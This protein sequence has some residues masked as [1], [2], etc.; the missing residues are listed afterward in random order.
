MSGEGQYLQLPPAHPRGA[1]RAA[2]QGVGTHNMGPGTAQQPAAHQSSQPQAPSSSSAATLRAGADGAPPAGPGAASRHAHSGSAFEAAE[3]AAAPSEV[4]SEIVS[5]ARNTVDD[6]IDADIF[7]DVD[8]ADVGVVPAN[9]GVPGWQASGVG[10]EVAGET[11]DEGAAGESDSER[12]TTVQSEASTAGGKKTKRRTRRKGK[13]TIRINLEECK[14]EVMR[15][16]RKQVGWREASGDQWWDVR[17][18]DTSVGLERIMRLRRLQKINHFHGMLEICRKNRMARN[19]RRMQRVLPDDFA[20]VPKTYILP[21]DSNELA[22]AIRSRRKRTFIVKPDAGCQ[23]KG[24]RLVQTQEQLARVLAELEMLGQANVVAQRYLSKPLLINGYKFD[25]RIYVL[26]AAVDPLRVFMYEDGLV[27]FA[28]SPYEAP[29]GG[30]LDTA[31]MHLTNYSLNKRTEGFQAASTLDG[32]DG[33]KWSLSAL[34]AWMSG[35]GHDYDKLMDEIGAIAVKTVMSIQ[36]LL[37][38]YYWSAVPAQNDGFSCFEVLGLDIMIDESLQPVMIECNHSPSFST[39]SDLDLQIKERLLR[40]TLVLVDADPRRAAQAKTRERKDTASRLLTS[41]PASLSSQMTAEDVAELRAKAQRRRDKREAVLL[42]QTGYQRVYPDPR[43][44]RAAMYERVIA[45]SREVFEGISALAKSRA[46]LSKAASKAAAAKAALSGTVGSA[47]PKRKV[48]LTMPDGSQVV[49]HDDPSDQDSDAVLRARARRA[50]GAALAK[51]PALPAATTRAASGPGS[52]RPQANGDGVWTLPTTVTPLL[53]TGESH[54]MVPAP[55]SDSQPRPPPEID[56]VAQAQSA[57]AAAATA[58]QQHLASRESATMAAAAALLSAAV[59]GPLQS[60]RQPGRRSSLPD[61]DPRRVLQS[62]A[63]MSITQMQDSLRAAGRNATPPST[64]LRLASSLPDTGGLLSQP[65]TLPPGLPSAIEALLERSGD[66]SAHSDKWVPSAARDTGV[67]PRPVVRSNS[68]T[69]SPSEGPPTRSAVP[70]QLLSIPTGNSGESL[71]PRQVPNALSALLRR[72][73]SSSQ[74]A[75]GPPAAPVLLRQPPAG[76]PAKPASLH[77]LSDGSGAPAPAVPA[78]TDWIGRVSVRTG[79]TLQRAGSAGRAEPTAA[80]SA[81]GSAQDSVALGGRA[82]GA[83]VALPAVPGSSAHTEGGVS[84]PQSHGV[85]HFHSS[86]MILSV[87]AMPGRTDRGVRR[88]GSSVGRTARSVLDKPRG[89]FDP[90][91]LQSGLVV[92]GMAGGR[93][94]KSLIGDG[95]RRAIAMPNTSLGRR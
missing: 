22:D 23:G 73:S 69:R 88:A 37:Q 55:Q 90:P 7:D 29:K 63:G 28:T 19:I 8:D 13:Y 94:G 47:P 91:S 45:G 49:A 83:T 42:P 87:P 18:V 89:A 54:R 62:K 40:D 58:A 16:V 78:R 53:V 67:P 43:P 86:G 34:R 11:D 5:I 46:G 95:A 50:S 25:L 79:R 74:N 26:V 33:A 32:S 38:H 51:P 85:G 93:S 44:E 30:N 15:S 31:T 77:V 80:P 35:E 52:R 39:E 76:A 70:P 24:I 72:A 27:R 84:A 3:G 66:A 75:D 65:E 57:A 36:P 41:K 82:G 6:E 2:E 20:Y 68:R 10:D 14:Y 17:W 9:G 4:S 12:L 81:G 1:E 59:G 56:V 48:M 21:E 60:A 61:V 71:G 92:E 64:G